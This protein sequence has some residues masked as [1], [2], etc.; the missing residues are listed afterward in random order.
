M[1][2]DLDGD[3]IQDASEPGVA[4]VAVALVSG[5]DTVV[6]STVS[7]TNGAYA[8]G[9]V[10]AGPYRVRFGPLPAGWQFTAQ[11]GGGNDFLDSDADRVTGETAVIPFA[12]GFYSS[13][14]AGLV[15]GGPVPLLGELGDFVW[16]DFDRD[17][18]QDPGEPGVAGIVVELRDGDDLT[19]DEDV[20]DGAGQYRFTGVPAGSYRLRFVTPG[21]TL[22]S[23]QGQGGDDTVDS[24]P[25]PDGLTGL[26]TLDAG[27][28]D[29][30]IDAG[31]VVPS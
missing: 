11:N 20:T 27:E 16:R 7:D 18:I 29:T 15:A 4:G 19:I 5:P 1:W 23:P 8:L 2:D 24:D 12:G 14:D 6:A 25:R 10:P 21:G 30:S 22:F 31:L 3:G 26:V 9:P 17:G 13:I 28:I